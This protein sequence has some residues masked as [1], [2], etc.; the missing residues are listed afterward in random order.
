MCVACSSITREVEAG[1][2]VV[3]NHPDYIKFEASLGYI[4]PFL[5]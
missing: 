5:S 1:R 4:R 2:S 3:Q